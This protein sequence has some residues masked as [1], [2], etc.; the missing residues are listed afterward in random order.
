MIVVEL[1]S[2][3]ELE[4]SG[5][6][7]VRWRK[8]TAPLLWSPK[9]Q[10]LFVLERTKKGRNRPIPPDTPSDVRRSFESW[11]HRGATRKRTDSV[12][13]IGASWRSCGQ[14]V[15]LDYASDKWGV[16]REYTHDTGP[17]VRLYSYG[18]T[19]RP[20]CWAIHGGRLTVTTRGIVG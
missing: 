15:R 16:K 19:S 7:V 17:R 13:S 20:S 18:T 8:H 14:V 12:T 10:A 6:V 5:G 2:A 1:G 9:K 11:A 3:L 4:L